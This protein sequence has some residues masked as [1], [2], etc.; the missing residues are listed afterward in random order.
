[1]NN[2]APSKSPQSNGGSPEDCRPQQDQSP[3]TTKDPPDGGNGKLKSNDSDTLMHTIKEQER[4]GRMNPAI[5][6]AFNNTSSGALDTS[7][8]GSKSSNKQVRTTAS[9]ARKQ[10]AEIKNGP[11]SN[12]TTDDR[13]HQQTS[14]TGNDWMKEI[15]E[16]ERITR[17]NPAIGLALNNNTSHG[18]LPPPAA[19][20]ASRKHTTRTSTPATATQIDNAGIESTGQKKNGAPKETPPTL[21]QPG[22]YPEKMETTMNSAHIALSAMK[23]ARFENFQ[24]SGQLSFLPKK[25]F[26]A[27]NGSSVTSPTF[28][29]PTRTHPEKKE[30]GESYL[31][32]SPD[33]PMKAI[34]KRSRQPDPVPDPVMTLDA[35]APTSETTATI[36]TANGEV[37]REEEDDSITYSRQAKKRIAGPVQPGAFG[38]APGMQPTRVASLRYCSPAQPEPDDSQHNPYQIADTPHDPTTLPVLTEAGTR[39]AMGLVEARAVTES[40]S[41]IFGRADSYRGPTADE[42]QQNREQKKYYYVGTILCMAL[43]PII[44]VLILL[45]SGVFDKATKDSVVISTE[46]PS[47]APSGSPTIAPTPF[48]LP[49]P[50][51]TV[52]TLQNGPLDSPQER[53]YRWIQDDPN[54]E[55][56]SDA[57]KQQRFALTTIY[58]ATN[59]EAWDIN[60]NWLS[61][62]DHEC[63]WQTKGVGLLGDGM[64]RHCDPGGNFLYLYLTKN[65]LSGSL[66]PEFLTGTIPTEIGRVT[67]LESLYLHA[68]QLTGEV[69]SEIGQLTLLERLWVQNNPVAGTIMTE[70]GLL[71]NLISLQWRETMTRGT[72]PTEL[73]LL[74]NQTRFLSLRTQFLTGTIP[75]EIG[76]M[77]A[78]ESL[79]LNANQLTGEVPS[80]I[81]QLTLLERF[82]VR[83]NPVAG[84]IM[85]EVGLLTN[86]IGFEWADTMTR[87][88]INPVTGT[89]MTEVGLLTNMIDFEWAD[90]MTEFLTGTIPAEI[91]TMTNLESLYLDDLFLSGT[92]PSEFGSFVKIEELFVHTNQLT[93]EVPSEIGQL[94]HLEQFSV[95]TNPV[96]GT[97]MTE[98]GRLTNMIELDWADTMT[99]GTIPT[100]LGLLTRMTSAFL[101][102]NL[103]DGQIPSELGLL[104]NLSHTLSLYTQFL[105]GTIPTEIGRLTDLEFLYLDDLLLTGTILSEIGSFVNNDNNLWGAIPSELGGL[106]L[107]EDLFLSS[108]SLSGSIPSE[109][110]G[111]SSLIWLSL[112]D[113][114][115]SGTVPLELGNVALSGVLEMLSL[116]G[117][118]LTDWIPSDLCLIPDLNFDCSD[119][120]CGCNCV[121]Q[122]GAQ[123]SVLGRP[124]S[125]E[126][127]AKEP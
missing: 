45:W 13:Q 89:I 98:L 9:P 39:T 14:R 21:P 44:I 10:K 75:T 42:A 120:L 47:N 74:S 114:N 101:E 6:L 99:R 32:H 110:G 92:I 97:I 54:F 1:M 122:F 70:V 16:Q 11:K 83:N 38:A 100:E 52:D 112:H 72:L 68:N 109:L 60:E 36:G 15:K 108:T 27:N 23:A 66:P 57:Q 35:S 119:D 87:V 12:S 85:A 103:F 84:T 29:Q 73:G 91:G 58:Y 55:D 49:L 30:K 96:T 43:V 2:E 121:C 104:S 117:T 41:T 17:Q 31:S 56:Y 46:A 24:S 53:A 113:T 63:L 86:M 51:Y 90:T 71:T 4:I 50:E 40:T 105:T 125:A 111:L 59:G 115:L 64:T 124:G 20:A 33:D 118:L 69:P 127:D 123:A 81:G 106:T 78:L 65:G 34:V 102:Q 62:A 5:A 26:T 80:E 25:S 77:T 37:F 28:P 126:G 61:Y 48:F 93:G 88:Q 8:K 67:D 107:L 18:S 19:A 82:W 95:H 79:Y 116:N 22:T 3:P 76:R 94:T 7:P